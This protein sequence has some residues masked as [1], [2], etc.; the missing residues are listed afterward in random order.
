VNGAPVSPREGH[1]FYDEAARERPYGRLVEFLRER[2]RL[3]EA[4]PA[5]H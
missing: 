4:P 1:G 3:E 5:A 2:A